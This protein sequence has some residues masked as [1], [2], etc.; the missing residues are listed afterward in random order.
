MHTILRSPF[1][2][3]SG[4]TEILSD[5]FKPENINNQLPTKQV[6]EYIG[7]IQTSSEHT[8]KLIEDLMDWAKI[9]SGNISY[10]PKLINVNDLVES[11]YQPLKL[12]AN[13]K[14]ITITNN[15]KKD[16]EVYV[17]K[18]SANTILRN[19]IN[20]SIKFTNN[21]GKIEITGNLIT[22]NN[23]Q[24]YYEIDITDNGIGMNSEIIANLYANN[25]NNL[26]R[27]G[28]ADEKGTNLGISMVHE[29]I[30]LNHGKMYIESLGE[31]KGSTFKILFPIKPI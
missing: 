14:F 26:S 23:N 30:K 17:D 1:T 25:I 21:Y 5:N 22:E 27:K 18:Y 13:N 10:S 29:H 7:Y 6:E 28:T 16:A 9:Q 4:F 8:L 11:S 15:Q 12:S 31:N 20:N 2:A 19:I 3:I 24:Q